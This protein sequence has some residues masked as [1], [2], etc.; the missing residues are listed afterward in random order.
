MRTAEA[1]RLVGKDISWNDRRDVLTL[2]HPPLRRGTLREVQGK[3][4]HIDVLGSLD[5][6][7]L[8]DMLN[9]REVKAVP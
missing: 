6:K 3:N 4:A 7:W 5:W 8:P 9:V 2:V 1:R